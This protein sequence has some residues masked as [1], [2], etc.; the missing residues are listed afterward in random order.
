MN[1][2]FNGCFLNTM[3]SFIPVPKRFTNPIECQT[4]KPLTIECIGKGEE[5][6]SFI[7]VLYFS[8]CGI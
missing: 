2:M 7:E 6:I 1:R 4:R 5:L 8:I 3:L